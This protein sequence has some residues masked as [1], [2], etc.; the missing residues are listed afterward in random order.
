MIKDLTM[1][2]VNRDDMTGYDE[3]IKENDEFFEYYQKQGIVDGDEWDDFVKSLRTELP[4]SFR[5][6][7]S[8]PECEWLLNYLNQKYLRP[9]ENL[10]GE[11][12]IKALQIPFIPGAF[13]I[14]ASKQSVRR[15]PILKNLHEFLVD[16]TAIVYEKHNRIRL[17]H[18][19]L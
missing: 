15:N 8:L 12:N 1:T 18:S 13:Q 17:R 2:T 6:Q 7:T 11:D 19:D 4:T 3:C 16:E 5:V 10:P 14:E 9:L